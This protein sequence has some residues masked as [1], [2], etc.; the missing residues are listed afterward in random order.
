M[1][2]DP[3]RGGHYSAVRARYLRETQPE[4]VAF[5]YKLEITCGRTEV[6]SEPLYN[7]IVASLTD[8]LPTHPIPLGGGH[9]VPDT[10]TRPGEQVPHNGD[11]RDVRRVWPLLHRDATPRALPIGHCPPVHPITAPETGAWPFPTGS[12][13]RVVFST[14]ACAKPWVRLV[15]VSPALPFIFQMPHIGCS[16][17]ASCW[18]SSQEHPRTYVSRILGAGRCGAAADV[19]PSP[20]DLGGDSRRHQA[21]EHPPHPE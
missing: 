1:P 3:S 10:A 13:A 4:H 7:L 16:G 17:S 8:R 18:L 11:P 19:A 12:R 21:R 14:S 6:H 5:F 20:R 15:A 9:T 2:A